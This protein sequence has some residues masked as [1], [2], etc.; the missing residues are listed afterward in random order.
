[1]FFCLCSQVTCHIIGSEMALW[2]K[3]LA[4]KSGY[5]SSVPGIHVV[6]GETNLLLLPV[7]LP[8]TP[9]ILVMHACPSTD[10]CE[11]S[12]DSWAVYTEF[13]NSLGFLS[14][15]A[16]KEERNEFKMSE[17]I[18]CCCFVVVGGVCVC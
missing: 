13:R 18:L 14:K 11:S 8:R 4:T 1:M 16:A 12:E 9:R 5:L 15:A 7:D 3:V 2:V 10:D 6:K 17:I